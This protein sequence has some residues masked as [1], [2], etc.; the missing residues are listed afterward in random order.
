MIYFYNYL[1]IL[2]D[3]RTIY[4]LRVSEESWPFKTF[5]QNLA[6]EK[7]LSDS[8]IQILNSLSK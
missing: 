8:D 2:R 4:S 1:P 5:D 3:I 6:K 7:I